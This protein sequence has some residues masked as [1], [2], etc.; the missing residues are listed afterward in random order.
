MVLACDPDTAVGL[1]RLGMT[2]FALL[3]EQ[4]PAAPAMLLSPLSV[5]GA[6]A[7]VL[8]GATPGDQSE[9]ELSKLLGSQ[10]GPVA[11]LTQSLLAAGAGRGGVSLQVA[12][13]VWSKGSI[14]PSFLELVRGVHRADASSLPS[15]YAPINDWVASKT[16]G[17]I[18]Q[19]LSG[20]PDTLVVAVLVNA[21]LFKGSWA[22]QFDPKQT[23]PGHFH[24][25]AEASPLDA[26]FMHR[27]AKMYAAASVAGLG[28]S[29]AVR[30]D[31]GE[32]G[33]PFCALLVLPASP[34]SEALAHAVE[35]LS[36]TGM[37][38][39][40]ESLT[41]QETSVALPRFR[42]ETE[43]I[44][45]VPV[46]RR[47]GLNWVFEGGFGRMSDDA[48][49]HLSEVV[50]KV[51]IEVNEEGTVAAAATAAVVRTRSMPPPH[52]QLRFDRP[53]V[54]AVVHVPTGLPLFLARI[55]RPNFS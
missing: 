48:D 5:S 17:K 1:A 35:G 3:C 55:S 27:K 23:R 13:S 32:D 50:H 40:L 33:G 12:N 43:P 9:H 54:M 45:L 6:L 28:G 21:V 19:I 24:A 44:S 2:L 29:A 53:F 30:L 16:D 42:A 47:S 36:S 31:Y 18:T 22:A 39:V 52:L 11:E 8:A 41:Q 37:K 26:H 4:E 10:H 25:S 7:L 14:K 46:L 49:V 51:V 38:S 34:G 20:A 15:T